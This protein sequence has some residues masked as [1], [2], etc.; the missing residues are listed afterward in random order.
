L[1]EW[2]GEVDDD[3]GALKPAGDDVLKVWQV[4]RQVNSPKM[5]PSCWKQWQPK[6]LEAVA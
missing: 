2:L 3:P 6:L 5:A 4:S 1:A